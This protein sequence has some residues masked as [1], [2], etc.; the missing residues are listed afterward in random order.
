MRTHF[1]GKITVKLLSNSGN[2][3][4]LNFKFLRDN[5]YERS[6]GIACDYLLVKGSFMIKTFE[7]YTA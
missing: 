1:F 6:F 3:S 4:E 7:E 5:D 2:V